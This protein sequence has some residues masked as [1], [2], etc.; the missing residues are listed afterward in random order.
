MPVHLILNDHR[1][2]I[3][4]CHAGELGDS[5]YAYEIGEFRQLMLTEG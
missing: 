5:V 4:R 3:R 2:R 1:L